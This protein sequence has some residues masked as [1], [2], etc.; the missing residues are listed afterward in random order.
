MNIKENLIGQRF[1]KWLVIDKSEKRS[2][3]GRI[4]WI[5]QCECGTI[6]EILRDSLKSGKTKGAERVNV[7][8]ILKI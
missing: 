1:G 5:C 8:A 2:K 6:S 7:Q 3:H 4:L